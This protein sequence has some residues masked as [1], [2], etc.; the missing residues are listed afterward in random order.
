MADNELKFI[1]RMR[2]EASAI[3]KAHGMAVGDAGGGSDAAKVEQAIGA[4][5]REQGAVLFGDAAPAACLG[6]GEGG[7]FL[8][9][10]AG[11]CGAKL[12]LGERRRDGGGNFLR[13]V[14]ALTP[15]R[16]EFRRGAD[17]AIACLVFIRANQ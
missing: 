9:E 5:E 13:Q 16:P 6:G 2:D 12:G 17:S 7:L 4:A 3:L 10:A 8:S 11:E 14:F 1:L 15:E